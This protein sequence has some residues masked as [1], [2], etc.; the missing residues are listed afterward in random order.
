MHAL[1]LLSIN[2]QKK[3]EMPSFTMSKNRI[4]AKNVK[5]GSRDPD[6]AIFRGGLLPLS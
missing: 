2:Q 3:F 6:H 5:N 4:V 1:A